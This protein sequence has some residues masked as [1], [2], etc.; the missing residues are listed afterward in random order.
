MTLGCTPG[1]L[2]QRD[3]SSLILSLP[4]SEILSNLWFLTSSENYKCMFS[5]MFLA[6]GSEK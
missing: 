5:V 1:R 3:S 4:V 6:T 2:V